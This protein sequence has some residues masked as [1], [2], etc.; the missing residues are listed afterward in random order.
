MSILLTYQTFHVVLNTPVIKEM[1]TVVLLLT[2]LLEFLLPDINKP[3]ALWTDL[4]NTN[5]VLSKLIRWISI[6]KSNKDISFN[7]SALIIRFEL[8]D[9]PDVTEV[10]LSKDGKIP[11]ELWTT[12]FTKLENSQLI[13]REFDSTKNV[14]YFTR[15][16]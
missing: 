14:T 2:D 12:I 11:N 15:I 1:N 16:K 3:V 10:D 13:K 9:S 6:N 8:D 7:H 4:R 5:M